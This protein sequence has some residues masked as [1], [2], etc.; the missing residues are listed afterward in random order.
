MP[1]YLIIA[2]YQT[3][4]IRGVASAGGTARR[5]AIEKMTA[6]VG[7]RMESFD[8]AFGDDDAYV[9]VELPDDKTAAAV[10]MAVNG[11]GTTRARTVVLL[12][13]EEVDAAAQLKVGYVPPGQ[14]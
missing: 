8:F 12:T 1:R 9:R 10:A 7:G 6:D 3:E 2:Q 4:G 11:S 14:T 5:T 13:P